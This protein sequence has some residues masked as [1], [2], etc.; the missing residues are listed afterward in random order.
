MIKK[1][2]GFIFRLILIAVIIGVPCTWMIRRSYNNPE[3]HYYEREEQKGTESL[4][5]AI[6]SDLNGYVFAGGN[7]QIVDNIAAVSPDAILMAGDMISAG[8]E[9]VSSTVSLIERLSAIAPV[10]YAYGEQEYLYVSGG[11]A[12]HSL[13]MSGETQ[14]EKE[15]DTQITEAGATVLKESYIDTMLYGI[16]LRI[17]STDGSARSLVMGNGQINPVGERLNALLTDFKDTKSYKIMLSNKVDHFL[18]V[19]EEIMDGI[20]LTV[21]GHLIGG[22][23]VVPYFGGVFGGVQGYFPTFT[24]GFDNGSSKP[25]LLTTGLSAVKDRVPRFN[26]PPEIAVLDVSGLTR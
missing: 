18:G 16:P 2:L 10:Y 23:V 24:C 17:G 7:S 19:P 12:D 1:I 5:F 8:E 22:R 3:V 20:D 11:A 13:A 21:C 14:K 9:N 26:N 25:L 15:F 4:R 6:L